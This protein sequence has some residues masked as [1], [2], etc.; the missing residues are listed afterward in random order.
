MEVTYSWKGGNM[1]YSQTRLDIEKY[2]NAINSNFSKINKIKQQI[3]D[4]EDVNVE[5]QK[6]LEKFVEFNNFYL[7]KTE[8]EQNSFSTV[9]SV[10]KH[11]ERVR[12]F[13]SSTEYARAIEG[14]ENN[15][16]LVDKKINEL[17][18][19]CSMLNADISKYE[20]KIAMLMF[21]LRNEK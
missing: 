15:I 11:Y 21:Q 5:I 1:D 2:E 8:E 3:E 9:M 17:Y 19:E 20:E 6:D 12:E 7:N 16:N 14:I 18:D 10:I 4:L 13:L